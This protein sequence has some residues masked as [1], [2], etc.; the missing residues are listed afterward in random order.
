MSH[1][2][3]RQREPRLEIPALRKSAN[4]MPCTIQRVG[5][6]NG[7]EDTTVWCH[8]PFGK[9]KGV[10]MKAHDSN[11]CFGCGPCHDWLDRT[12]DPERREVF[13]RAKDRSYYLL[14]ERG[15]LKVV[16]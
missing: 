10:G 13:E 16:P 7:R 4:G 1:G 8:S 12:R 3:V 2:Q 14:F 11:G 5:T 9:D 6:C 15:K